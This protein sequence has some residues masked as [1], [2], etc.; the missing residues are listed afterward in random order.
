M[1]QF[2]FLFWHFFQ[3]INFWQITNNDHAH[4]IYDKLHIRTTSFFPNSNYVFWLGL[5]KWTSKIED[6]PISLGL[7]GSTRRS[8]PF[9]TREKNSFK[10]NIIIIIPVTTNFSAAFHGLYLLA[11]QSHSLQFLFSFWVEHIDKRLRRMSNKRSLS[12]TMIKFTSR[13]FLGLSPL[14]SRKD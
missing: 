13:K 10:M 4:S 12:A 6:F 3:R 2:H 1:G 5:T 8:K 14:N 11:A 9:K 7:S